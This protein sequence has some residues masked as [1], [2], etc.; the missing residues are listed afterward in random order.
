MF[1]PRNVTNPA[2]DKTASF[3]FFV[4]VENNRDTTKH[5]Q[6]MDAAIELAKQ[7]SLNGEVPVGCV[8]VHEETIIGQGA[9]EREQSQEP[10]RHAEITA[11]QQAARSLGSW[12]LEDTTLYVTLEPCPMCAGD[13]KSVV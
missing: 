2:L 4:P 9:N 1:D 7:A 12:R 13:R 11:I 6:Y 8:I 5:E 3:C 10:I